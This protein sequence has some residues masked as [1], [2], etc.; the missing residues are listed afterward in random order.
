MQIVV[1][2]VDGV[3]GQRKQFIQLFEYLR[4]VCNDSFIH[5]KK[6]KE[7][8]KAPDR[9]QG[10]GLLRQ[11]LCWQLGVQCLVQPVDDAN[12][13]FEVQRGRIEDWQFL[14]GG[15]ESFHLAHG[16]LG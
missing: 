11:M 9:S 3:V 8:R 6:G 5:D 10:L 12:R 7:T 2:L 14:A 13:V 15:V 4:V 1:D 16:T